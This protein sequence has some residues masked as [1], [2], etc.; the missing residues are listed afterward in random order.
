MRFTGV[1]R[2]IY[3]VLL[4]ALWAEPAAGVGAGG[5]IVHQSGDSAT[6][7]AVESV[8]ESAVDPTIEQGSR[9]AARNLLLAGIATAAVVALLSGVFAIWRKQHPQASGGK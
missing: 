6:S 3:W 4:A 5:V 2:T 1:H 7:R 9:G 8:E